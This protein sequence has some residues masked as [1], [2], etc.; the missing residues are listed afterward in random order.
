[1]T[2]NEMRMWEEGVR[3]CELGQCVAI[4]LRSLDTFKGSCDVLMSLTGRAL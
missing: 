3:A 4:R 1:M 2:H